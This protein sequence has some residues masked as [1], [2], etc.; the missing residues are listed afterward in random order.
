MPQDQF[1][2]GV[3]QLTLSFTDNIAQRRFDGTLS[4][5]VP[6]TELLLN[7]VITSIEDRI[8][9]DYTAQRF[10]DCY[11]EF[12]QGIGF[13]DGLETAALALQFNKIRDSTYQP[14]IATREYIW[15]NYLKSKAYKDL[16]P[17]GPQTSLY[18]ETRS[19]YQE[20][21]LLATQYIFARTLFIGMTGHLKT[22]VSDDDVVFLVQS[23]SRAVEHNIPYL[24]KILR[25]FEQGKISDLPTLAALIKH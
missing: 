21:V 16:T 13:K 7:V 14:Y 3:P 24:T 9:S 22:L 25:S 2:L 17:F 10:L 8:K 15:E 1:E 11:Q 23:F 19:I 20:F 4:G 6:N 5:I 12:I 18:A